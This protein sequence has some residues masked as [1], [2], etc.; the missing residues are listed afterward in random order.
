MYYG[1]P[2]PRLNK[3]ERHIELLRGKNIYFR[4]VTN[5]HIYIF[6]R[7]L[8]QTQRDHSSAA[9]LATSDPFLYTYIRFLFVGVS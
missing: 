3:E 2:T 8:R 9:V 1:R 7:I 4:L 5:R 6:A